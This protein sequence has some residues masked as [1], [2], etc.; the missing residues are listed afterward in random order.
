MDRAVGAAH[1]AAPT[2]KIVEAYAGKV[3]ADGN[4]GSRARTM[5]TI[6]AQIVVIATPEAVWQVLTDIAEY[7]T[8]H[9]YVEL[10]G[11]L[12]AG[13]KID[14]FFRANPGKP[15]GAPVTATITQFD[16]PVRFS[17]KFGIPGICTIE[18]WFALGE[19]PN[20]TRITHGSNFQGLLPGLAM[21]FARK[22]LM[23][24]HTAPLQG[25]AR[26]L[27]TIRSN[28]LSPPTKRTPSPP[29]GFRG[30]TRQ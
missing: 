20:G 5:T 25:L 1:P 4:I 3:T 12:K 2:A 14:Y 28:G 23:A 30:Y 18:H 7:R 10:D 26:R 24:F 29:K 17:L 16:D 21:R 6:S 22:R 27:Q 11:K 19:V 9:P 13:S 15:R 8:W